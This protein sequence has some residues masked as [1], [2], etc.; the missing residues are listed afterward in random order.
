M[1]PISKIFALA[2]L[3]SMTTPALA[4]I[5]PSMTPLATA[6]K[7]INFKRGSTQMQGAQ[8]GI[9]GFSGGLIAILALIPIVALVVIVADEGGD[10]PTSN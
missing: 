9:A 4:E 1:R 5:R 3:A 7:S 8:G 2:A 6:G 10:N